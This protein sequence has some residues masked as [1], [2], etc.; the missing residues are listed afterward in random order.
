MKWKTVEK[1]KVIFLHRILYLFW[2]IQCNKKT[3]TSDGNSGV[4]HLLRYS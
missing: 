3:Q 2:I 4:R 1:H